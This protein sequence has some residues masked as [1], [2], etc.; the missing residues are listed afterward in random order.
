MSVLNFVKCQWISRVRR[1]H[2]PEIRNGHPAVLEILAIAD[3]E[4]RCEHGCNVLIK[5]S[6]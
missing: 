6:I 3:P 5:E 1:I 2:P 4:P